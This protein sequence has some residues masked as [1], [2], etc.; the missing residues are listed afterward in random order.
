MKISNGNFDFLNK[1]KQNNNKNW[2]IENKD[3]Y[4]KSLQNSIDFSDSVLHLLQ[5]HDTIET[6][7]GKKSLYRIYR[8]IRFSKDKTPFKTHWGIHYKRATSLLR[9]GYGIHIEPNNTLVGGGFWSPSKEDLLHI[10]LQI[11]QSPEELKT[12]LQNKNFIHH[13]GLLK[14]DKLKTFPKGFSIDNNAIDLL[15]Y[16]Q[17]LVIKT[18]TNEEVLKNDFVAQVDETF[19]AMRPFLN[20]MS[21]ILTTDLNGELLKN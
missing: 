11:E 2:F 5:Q 3:W 18:F 20:Y 16:K 13:F 19:R 7:N 14:G 10:R 15:Q 4:D 9:G 1:I 12:I 17:F 6:L 8:D 21:E